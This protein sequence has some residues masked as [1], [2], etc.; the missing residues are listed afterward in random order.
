MAQRSGPLAEQLRAQ[1]L[2][3]RTS[4][5]GRAQGY[6]T[7]TIAARFGIGETTVRD[8]STGRRG[9]SE[10]NAEKALRTFAETRPEIETLT[11]RD[12]SRLGTYMNLR[13]EAQRTGDAGLIERRMG[14]NVVIQTA[15]GPLV[16]E[17]RPAVLRAETDAGIDPYRDQRIVSPKKSRRRRGA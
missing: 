10:T 6:S 7:R 9:I 15:D 13:K 2:A 5:P 17:T 3:M 16:L 4:K 14:R 11:R 8:L 12:A 1:I